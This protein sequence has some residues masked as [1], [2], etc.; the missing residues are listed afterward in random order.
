MLFEKFLIH[1]SVGQNLFYSSPAL[2]TPLGT[3]GYWNLNQ[4]QL[5]KIKNS[6]IS[7]T[8]HMQPHDSWLPYWTVQNIPIITEGGVGRHCSR[9]LNGLCL[10]FWPTHRS[11]CRAILCCH[12]ISVPPF[13][14]SIYF[15]W[16]KIFFNCE[17]NG[18]RKKRTNSTPH[19]ASL[20]ILNWL[21][22]GW[23]TRFNILLSWN[24]NSAG[25]QITVYIKYTK[26]LLLKWK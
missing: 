16:K 17:E 10:N 24:L 11:Y 25:G 21:F 13:P 26:I 4:L 15:N 3:C 18:W 22:G 7:H 14:D 20:E 1:Q 5:S 23:L 9:S 6:G 19:S 8:A 12:L 2:S